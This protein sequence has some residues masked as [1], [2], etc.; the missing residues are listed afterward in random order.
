MKQ[1]VI[2]A[3]IGIPI[4]LAAICY[5]EPIYFS[6]LVAIAGALALFEFSNLCR[7]SLLEFVVSQL[8][9]LAIFFAPTL[10]ILEMHSL[11]VAAVSLFSPLLIFSQ[12]SWLRQ[13]GGLL[14]IGI[15]LAMLALFQMR[16]TLSFTQPFQASQALLVLVPIWA[17]DSAAI[18]AGKAFGKHMLAPTIS[19]KKTWEG[20]IANLVACIGIA[21]V[22]GQL[23]R[24]AWLPSLFC[25]VSCGILG[26]VGDLLESGLKRKYNAKDSGAILP[27]H[28]GV[29]DRIDSLLYSIPVCIAIL[30]HSR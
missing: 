26:Q 19:P 15:P 4:V 21:L 30:V 16:T 20:A 29:L 13:I 11:V 18:F 1:R 2:T 25:G 6:T 14:W 9:F 27:G 22:M 23:T 3:L 28:G 5:R 7:A 8:A 24:V 17:G 12:Q 10:E